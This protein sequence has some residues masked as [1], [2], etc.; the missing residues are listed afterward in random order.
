MLKLKLQYLGHLMK[1]G[2]SLEKSLML[3]KIEGRRRRG[4]QRMRQLDGIT[5]SM[6]LSF[7]QTLGG[8]QGSL[9][10]WS[11]WGRKQ[12]DTTDW[13]NWTELLNNEDILKQ[14]LSFLVKINCWIKQANCRTSWQFLRLSLLI[15]DLWPS[16]VHISSAWK[17]EVRAP[18]LSSHIPACAFLPVCL[19]TT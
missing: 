11:P 14:V 6:S 2:N 7:E 8:G 13:L 17:A 18:V 16:H 15:P 1:R 10:C 19:I 9:A 12:L 3:G 5:D 4:R